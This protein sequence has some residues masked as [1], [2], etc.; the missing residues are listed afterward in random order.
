MLWPGRAALPRRRLWF[1]PFTPQ[2]QA[3][4]LRPLR[5]ESGEPRRRRGRVGRV[6][7]WGCLLRRAAA[8]DGAAR[9]GA[10]DGAG[11][12]G[13][14]VHAQRRRCAARDGIPHLARGGLRSDRR[15]PRLVP[16]GR[17]HAVAPPARR[18]GGR[19]AGL[20]RT[21][22][23][24]AASAAAALVCVVRVRGT[25]GGGMR[26]RVGRGGRRSGGPAAQGLAVLV[27]GRAR[28][29]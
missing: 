11:D 25:G 4:F 26:G 3:A 18:R 22:W 17:S 12:S 29:R 27:G 8:R 7:V 6:R 19:F 13:A 20:C 28:R 16:R 5:V 10:V 2:F 23:G 15:G 9:G 21:E 1:G 24:L 14:R